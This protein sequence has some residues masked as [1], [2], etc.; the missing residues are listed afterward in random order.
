L[1]DYFRT[2]VKRKVD[3]DRTVALL[4]R[5]YEA[6]VGLMGKTVSLLYHARDL[7]RIEIYDDGK[8]AGF[9]TPLDMGINSKVKRQSHVKSELIPDYQ[10]NPDPQL[11]KPKSGSLFGEAP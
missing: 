7:N 6:P 3:K 5:L 10:E 2:P 8:S 4:G 11:Q 1:H 9:L